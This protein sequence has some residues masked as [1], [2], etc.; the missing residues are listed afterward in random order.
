MEG[1]MHTELQAM[2]SLL[3]EICELG[4][5]TEEKGI[6][7]LPSFNDLAE[8]ARNLGIPVSDTAT[9]DDLRAATENACTNATESATA[10]QNPVKAK[11]ILGNETGIPGDGP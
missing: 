8:K 6:V 5:T 7:R 9:L 1:D 11:M 4:A 2:Q 10:D 3:L